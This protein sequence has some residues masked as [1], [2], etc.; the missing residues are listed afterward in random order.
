MFYLLQRQAQNGT[1]IAGTVKLLYGG[2]HWDRG[3]NKEVS[4]K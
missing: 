2:H 3:K 4:V 1:Y